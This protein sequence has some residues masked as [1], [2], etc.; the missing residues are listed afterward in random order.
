MNILI[1]NVLDGRHACYLAYSVASNTLVLVD[2]GGH[3]EGPYAG[4][5]VLGSSAAIRNSQCGVTLA[6]ATGSGATLT[7][8][9][10]IAFQAGFGGNQVL[11]LAARDASQ[12]STD[13]QAMGV[14][15]VPWTP[16]GTIAAGSIGP[17][18]SSGPAGSSEML[19][20]TLTDTK[21]TADIGIV[22][23][24]VNGAIDGRQA[25]Y[26]A[27][28]A[29]GNMLLLVDDAGDAGGPF[30]GSL[31]LDGIPS[32]MSNAQCVI[33]SKGSSATRSG[34]TLTLTL[35]ISFQVG[36]FG[37]RILYL[38]GR[39]VTGGN[40]TGWQAMGTAAVQ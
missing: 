30:A 6:A 2:D 24:L 4:S 12:N 32:S 16:S 27:Y 28:V 39:D 13:W 17:D 3:A 11:Y 9:L 29:S 23:L 10:G 33:D 15:Q 7:L 35:N 1:N 8:S 19:V 21:G 37:N 26:L 31:P 34:N 18:R 38:A 14:W 40:N 36:L 20:L 25:C 22:N 5:V